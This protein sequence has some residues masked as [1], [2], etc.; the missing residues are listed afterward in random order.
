MVQSPLDA[1][2]RVA[3][4]SKKMVEKFIKALY[5]MAGFRI[6]FRGVFEGFSRTLTGPVKN[7][8]SGIISACQFKFCLMKLPPRLRLGRL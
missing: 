2:Y 4:R 5:L 8:L 1:G 6:E 3:S 7:G